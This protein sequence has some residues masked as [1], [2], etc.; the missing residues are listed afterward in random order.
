MTNEQ[1]ISWLK[2]YRKY[3][4]FEMPQY[5]DAFDMAIQA[6]QAQ[7]DGEYDGVYISYDLIS[8]QAVIDAI[9]DMEIL[10]YRIDLEKVI[11]ELPSVAIPSAEPKIDIVKMCIEE[12]LRQI[13]DYNHTGNKWHEGFAVAC[14]W[15]I[16]KY[17][18]GA[19]E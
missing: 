11:K 10:K 17:R 5:E 2:N 4:S 19:N 8:R 12:E 13:E 9:Y 1:A 14:R 16:D 18:K 3:T 6:L 15:I 7:A